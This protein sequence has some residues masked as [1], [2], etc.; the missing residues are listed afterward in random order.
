[1]GDHVVVIN[2]KEV[3]LT[4]NKWDKKLYRHHTGYV[5]VVITATLYVVRRLLTCDV[6]MSYCPSL[7]AIPE[8]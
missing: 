3:V 1:M 5:T 7:P 6:S 2:T 8:D 4:G